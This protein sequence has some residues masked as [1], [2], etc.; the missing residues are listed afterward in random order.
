MANRIPLPARCNCF[1]KSSASRLA[2]TGQITYQRFNSM[3]CAIEL[4]R[5]SLVQSALTLVWTLKIAQ[6]PH[7]I[8]VHANNYDR[9]FTFDHFQKRGLGT[10]KFE[11]EFEPILASRPSSIRSIGEHSLARYANVRW[12]WGDG[13][14]EHLVLRVYV[15]PFHA[16]FYGINVSIMRQNQ[17]LNKYTI[18]TW[19]W[20][21]FPQL[22]QWPS[23]ILEWVKLLAIP[24][25]RV[26]PSSSHLKPALVDLDHWYECDTVT[27][28]WKILKV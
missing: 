15:E 6:L 4:L 10:V 11:L 2:R 19:S 8:R 21:A 17:W 13:Q 7:L 24:F 23:T 18:F 9:I 12:I 14:Y 22:N 26:N 27:L 3:Q 16:L 1:T 28:F 20:I 5:N 25:H